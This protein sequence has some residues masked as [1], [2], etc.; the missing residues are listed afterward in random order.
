MS[1]GLD[2]D[3]ERR[4]VGPD[5]GRS[6]GPDLGANCLQRLSAP[7]SKERVTLVNVYVYLVVFTRIVGT[8]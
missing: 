7:A 5:L 8:S 3:Q 2:P 4:S 6:V 1:D